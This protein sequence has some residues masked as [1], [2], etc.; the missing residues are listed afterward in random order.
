MFKQNIFQSYDPIEQFALTNNDTFVTLP[1]FQVT[2]ANSYFWGLSFL[3]IIFLE[4]GLSSRF[5]VARFF[6]LKI[7]LF[8]REIVAST[9]TLI[10]Q[11][12]YIFL[13]CLF[14]T[15]LVSNLTGLLPYSYTVTSSLVSAFT[16]SF[17]A[18]GGIV[19]I[20]GERYGVHFLDRFLPAGVPYLIVPLL[21]VIEIISYLMRFFSL[22]IRL[23]ANMVSGHIL[24]KILISAS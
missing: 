23:F 8:V 6:L 2:G 14:L 3:L 20:G 15:L 24:I 22:A 19:V 5:L 1:M 21:M 13:I 11:R 18:V 9:I 17:L 10:N 7:F 16:L 4:I 12:F